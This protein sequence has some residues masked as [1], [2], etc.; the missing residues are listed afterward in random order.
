MTKRSSLYSKTPISPETIA[1][2]NI[3]TANYDVIADSVGADVNAVT[4]SGT[5]E[6]HGE[7]YYSYRDADKLVG[8]AGWLPSTNHNYPYL[9]YDKDWTGGFN[10]GGPI[11][12]DKLFFFLSAE[13]E[14]MNG[15]GVDSANGLDPS[16]AGAS[17]SGKISPGDLQKVI[18][19]AT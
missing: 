17:T 14:R 18:D 7:L 3:Q 1:E 9:N 10:I 19:A 13:R 11:I 6:F 16:L 2:Y 8:K 5:N 4:K 12:K 15:L